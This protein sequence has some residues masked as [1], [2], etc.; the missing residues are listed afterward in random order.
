VCLLTVFCLLFINFQKI[1][2][3]DDLK[4]EK[5][6]SLFYKILNF[7]LSRLSNF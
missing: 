4:N 3:L 5:L 6:E 1:Q 2:E 7:S